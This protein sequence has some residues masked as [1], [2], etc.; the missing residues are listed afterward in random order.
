MRKES[1][2]R[3]VKREKRSNSPEEPARVYRPRTLTLK[4]VD[5]NDQSDSKP[6]KRVSPRSDEH[7]PEP[8]RRSED[9]RRGDFRKP[10]S[11]NSEQPKSYRPRSWKKDSDSR[12]HEPRETSHERSSRPSRDE[13]KHESGRKNDG[14]KLV[15]HTRYNESKSKEYTRDNAKAEGMVA[16]KTADEL[17]RLN[18]YIANS[19]V[20]SR[21]EADEL[22]ANGMVTVNGK[23]V[24]ELGTKVR[25]DDV[26]MYKGKRLTAERKVYIL[27]NKPKD[28]VTTVDDPHAKHT[29]MELIE[30]ACDVRVYPVGRLDRNSTGVLLLTNDGDLTTRLTHP[31]FKKRKIYHVGLDRKVR[32]EDMNKIF[33]GVELDG[34]K[35]QVDAIDYVDGSD[36]SEVGIEIHSG[37]NRVV[38]RIFESLGYKVIKLDRVYFAGL[39]KKNLP[40]GKWR[41]LT[42]KEVNML[43]MNRFY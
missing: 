27:L 23:V 36:G 9:S 2:N 3:D 4:K 18:R 41:F 39:T 21:R 37:Q 29:V 8:K 30:G 22:I 16:K 24:T 14:F 38:R 26:V 13:R 7:K 35:I 12:E 43:K 1:M 28:Y 25:R 33:E 40:R 11:D 20:C 10:K 15:K 34:E 42:E 6:E 31:S 17:I 32:P 19:G 5:A